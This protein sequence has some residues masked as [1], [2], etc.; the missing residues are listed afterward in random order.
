MNKDDLICDYKLKECFGVDNMGNK[1]FYDYGHYTIDGA[2]FLGRRALK[3][4]WL[5][6]IN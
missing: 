6:K 4:K 3:I 1:I 2:Y 5:S